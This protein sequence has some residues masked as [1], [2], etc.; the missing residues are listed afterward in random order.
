MGGIPH[1]DAPGLR[2]IQ[3]DAQVALDRRIELP[4]VDFKES[5]T[6]DD[7]RWKVVRAALAMA[8]LRDGGLL[9]IGVSERDGKVEVTG[10]REEHIQT[11]DPDIMRDQVNAHASPFVELQIATVSYGEKRLLAIRV[12]EFRDTPVVC[13]KDGADKLMAGT[14]YVRPAGS[15]PE[16]TRIRD[17]TQLHDLLE[18]AAVKRARALIERASEAGMVPGQSSAARYAAE[19]GDL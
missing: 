16:A 14:I 10:I 13:K 8:N 3:D 19:L 4:E 12:L 11:F 1:S 5:G 6:W 17:A 15:K 7:L 2:H 18:R 9:L